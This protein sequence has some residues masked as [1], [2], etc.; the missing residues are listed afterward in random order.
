MTSLK[1]IAKKGRRIEAHRP[2]PRAV[3]TRDGWKAATQQLVDASATML[4][5]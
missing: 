4:G 5:L 3:V 1:D 2:W